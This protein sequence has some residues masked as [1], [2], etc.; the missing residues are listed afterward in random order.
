[1]QFKEQYILHYYHVDCI[2]ESFKRA[3]C[4]AN[5]ITDLNE[6][7]GVDEITDEE[8]SVISK[9]IKNLDLKKLEKENTAKKL[10]GT[11]ATDTTRIERNKLKPYNAASTK[12]LFTNGDQ[13]T[14]AK[15]S[16]LQQHIEREKPLIVAL[17][18][19]KPKNPLN[20]S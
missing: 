4:A 3:R 15:F 16:E 8:R 12:I 6:I 17:F 18:E 9:L 20:P 10:T 5:V 7:A 13:M 11:L 19:V 1:M 2:F 14:T